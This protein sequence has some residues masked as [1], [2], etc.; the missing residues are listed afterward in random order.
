MLSFII[1][2]P[3]LAAILISLLCHRQQRLARWVTLIVAIIE[4]GYLAIIWYKAP[5]TGAEFFYTEQYLWM[6]SLGIQYLLSMD[7]LSLM[8]CLLTVFIALIA[9][10]VAWRTID[11][12]SSFGPLLL[13][14]MAGIL[15]TFLALD[16]VLFYVFWELM[17]IPMFFMLTQWGGVG[18]VRAAIKFMLFTIAGSLLLLIAVIGLVTVH[19]Q[20]TGYYTFDYFHLLTTHYNGDL[21]I[22][23]FLGFLVAFAI[24]IPAIPVHFW[25]PDTYSEANPAVTILLSG[26]MANAGAYGIWRFCLML[27]PHASVAFADVGM[28]IGA[29]GVVYA[30]ILALVQSDMRRVAAYSSV[31][32]MGLVVFGLFA[33]QQQS[34]TGVLLLL[35]AHGVGVAGLFA[36]IGMLA[37]RGKMGNWKGLGGL[38]QPMPKLGV[39]LL[40]FILA[41]IGLPGLANFAGEFLILAGGLQQSVTWAVVGT[42]GI[43]ISVI[44][45]LK[46]YERTMLGPLPQQDTSVLV[47]INKREAVALG[48]LVIAIIWIGVYPMSFIKPIESS[49]ATL[50][51][52]KQYLL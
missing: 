10:L 19:G 25:A 48:L 4:L 34:L 51:T 12:W 42:L 11:R 50:L 23:L 22:W 24:K 44:Y 31:S 14:C 1:F 8:L 29:I 32:H 27:F 30:G 36:V 35:L 40:F 38:F 2:F 39:L 15:G 47:D 6:P 7:G 9:I 33:W 41:G 49:V 13:A 37:E 17:L 20:Q 28:A 5:L 26:A 3:I 46:L 18:R 52:A 45:F 43:L 16:L 21:A